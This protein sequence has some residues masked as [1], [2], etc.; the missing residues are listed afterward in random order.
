MQRVSATRSELLLRRGKIQLAEQGRDLLK[1]RR[2]ALVRELDSVGVSVLESMDLLARQAAD[3]RH[4]L[5]RSVAADGREPYESASLVAAQGVAVSLRA[6]RVAGVPVVTIHHG[7]V[8]RAR[9]SRG[10]SLAAT[11]ARTDGVAERFEAVLERLLDLA[12]LELSVRR[13]ATE[14]ARTTRRM[15]ALEHAV[16]PKL[17]A[18]QAHIQLV[19][20]ERE[21]EDLVRL[22]RVRTQLERS[23]RRHDDRE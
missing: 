2:S 5:G 1:E 15:N 18:E 14:I 6:R 13:L 10:Y 9:T 17:E 4:F 3:A 8:V 23:A 19:L 20:D 16:I 22:R 11:N 7:D 21:L 12:G